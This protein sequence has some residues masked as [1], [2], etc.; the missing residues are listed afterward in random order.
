MDAA[1]SS[2]PLPCIAPPGWSW[3]GE[4]CIQIGCGCSGADCGALYDSVGDCTETHAECAG[5]VFDAC[6]SPSDCTLTSA[7][8]CSPCVVVALT[9]YVA[10]TDERVASYREE[11][12]SEPQNSCL[13]P[14]IPEPTPSTFYATCEV[15]RCAPIDI[16]EWAQCT[17]DL[18]C[19]V[20]SRDCCETCTAPTDLS[21]LVAVSDPFSYGSL[22]CGLDP[23]CD[24]CSPNY[25]RARA[26]CI[27][28]HC[29]LMWVDT[30]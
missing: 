8:C 19:Q 12:C 22:V 21:D 30:R 20:R 18:D 7:G 3:D 15:G 26:Q 24:P 1:N 10:L 6:V 16:A 29:A 25:G 4:R 14:C 23:E 13:L 28:G 27:D 9:D 5:G 17:G 11:V 2:L